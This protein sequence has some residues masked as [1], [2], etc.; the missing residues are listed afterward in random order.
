VASFLELFV[1]GDTGWGDELFFGAI[2]T[3]QVA[4]LSYALGLILGLIGAA[5]RLSR[6]RFVSLVALG[7]SIVFRGLPELLVIS[8][9]YFGGSLAIRAVLSPFGFRGFIEFN[10]FVSGV[11]ALGL[12]MSAYVAELF[13]GAILAVPQGQSDAAHAL[14]LKRLQVFFLVVMPQAFRISLPGLANLWM[15]IL[16]NTALVSVIGLVDMV[17][18]AYFG[19]SSTRYPMPFFTAVALGYLVLT[20]VSQLVLTRLEAYAN[21]GVAEPATR[22]TIA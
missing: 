21:R 6:H 13:R 12:V 14:G 19:A 17:R 18:A 1:W 16:K 3:I 4:F 8:L 9:I 11:L 20:Y 15:T 22:G 7:Y 10:P 2:V 5:A